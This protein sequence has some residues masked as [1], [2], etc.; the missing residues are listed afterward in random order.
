MQ[1]TPEQTRARR[2]KAA[3]EGKLVTG[4]CHITV[5][6]SDLIKLIQRKSHD[7]QAV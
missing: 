6:L 2:E 1:E 5:K 3:R 7:T 4:E